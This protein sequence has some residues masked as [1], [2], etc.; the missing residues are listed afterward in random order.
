[1]KDYEIIVVG[2]GHAGIEA[3]LAASR[4]HH[5]TA[6]L[7]LNIDLIG[8]MPC[9]PSVGGPAKGIVVREVDALG[10]QMGKT[11]DATALQFKM[12]NSAKGPGV[13]AL[14]VQSDKL[15][16]SKMMKEVCLN[17]ENLDVIEGMAVKLNVENNKATGVTLK[18]GTVLTSDIVILTTGTYMA[19]VN[20]ISDEVKEGGPDLEETT[21]DLSASIREA[22]LKTFRLKTGTPARVLTSS[23]DFEKTNLEVGTDGF[24][25]FSQETKEILPFEKQV[26]C[27]MTYTTP[28]THE[29]IWANI[30]K[31]SVYSGVVK[32]VG[33]RYCPS[34]EDKLKR[35]QDKP[36]H[37]LFLEPESL[38]LDTTYV[39][40]FST[41]LPRD[42]Q[43]E[44][45]HSLP[46]FENCVIKKYAYAIEYDAIDPVQMLPSLENKYIE[47]FFTAGQVNGTSGYE[48]AAGQGLIAG[49][50]AVSKLEGTEPVILQRDEAYIGV[51]IDDLTTKGTKEPYRLLTSRAEFRLLL[52]HDNAE[53]RLIEIGYKK[54]LVSQERYDAYLERQ[55]QLQELKEELK[56]TVFLLDDEKVYAYLA[57]IGYD[58]NE[59]IGI[60][61]LNLIKRPNVTSYELFKSIGIEKDKQLCE[62][63][64]IEVKYEG[65]IN[66]AK[67]EAEKLSSMEEIKLGLDFNY[68]EVDNLSL[69]GRAK[70]MEYKPA[71]MGQASRISGV[72]PADIAV[73]AIAIRQGK[74][75]KAN[76]D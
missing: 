35:F 21:K 68:D 55:A 18:D 75:V 40:G 65:Y 20:M 73:L 58:R 17:Q 16:Y 66:K 43:E 23:I 36:R 27:Y 70:L 49:I 51:M 60:N 38:E 4:L 56:N 14:R 46:G 3:A 64:D 50:N 44:M 67:R 54:G 11:A 39:Q 53:E 2:G 6:L 47:N 1:M 19:G 69:E 34:I 30:N 29:I 32:G 37:L 13:R 41:S 12:L 74:G 33:P 61:G 25:T 10:G 22:G 76:E 59:H 7:T 9:N 28:K 26:P 24:Y 71:T 52:R 48:E 31:S 15:L 42:V 72:N 45:Y 8:K 57:S 63:L 62:K 5:K